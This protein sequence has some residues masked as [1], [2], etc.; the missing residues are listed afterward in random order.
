[1]CLSVN[2]LITFSFSIFIFGFIVV[3]YIISSFPP[4]Y[5]YF[6]VSCQICSTSFVI[7]FITGLN[8]LVHRP[9][10]SLLAHLSVMSFLVSLF[11]PF[12]LHGQTIVIVPWL[13][14]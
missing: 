10:G 7:C 2:A 4:T 11:C 8:F 5:L 3:C 12:F 13:T 9:I 14:L 1:M 6:S